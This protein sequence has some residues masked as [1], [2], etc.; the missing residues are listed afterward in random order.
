MPGVECIKEYVSCVRRG[1]TLP[2]Y[3]D[4]YY[5]N[6]NKIFDS[7]LGSNLENILLVFLN[8]FIF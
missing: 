4:I 6:K 3:R 7:L 8:E 1:W 5:E 2:E